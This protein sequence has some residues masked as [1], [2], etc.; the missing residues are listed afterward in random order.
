M[1]HTKQYFNNI[2][3]SGKIHFANV[4]FR[5]PSRP[6][7]SVLKGIDFQ[8]EAGQKVALVGPSGCGKSTLVKL[9]LK[10]YDF[11]GHVS[12]YLLHVLRDNACMYF[13]LLSCSLRLL[14]T[15]ST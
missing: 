6:E 15:K 2:V 12:Y 3:D 10:L 1:T 8:V 5:Y 9:L 7:I 14:W 13:F 11:D 4:S